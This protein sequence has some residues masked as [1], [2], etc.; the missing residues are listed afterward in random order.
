MIGVGRIGALLENDKL[1][2]KPCTHI[3]AYKVCPDVVVEAICD[4]DAKLVEETATLWGIPYVYTDYKYMLNMH[5]FNIISVATPV[6][7]HASIVTQIAQMAYSTHKPLIFCEKPLA[8]SPYEAEQMIK[9]CAKAEI[10][11]IVN[12]TRRWHSAYR[13]IKSMP[14]PQKVVAYVSGDPFNDGIHAFDLFNWWGAKENIYIPVVSKYLIFEL[15]IF[16]QDER[17]RIINNGRY[18]EHWRSEPSEFYEGYEELHLIGTQTQPQQARRFKEKPMTRA[19]ENIVDV[20]NGKSQPACTG[21]D[22]LKALEAYT[23]WKFG[24]G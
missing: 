9:E 3:G 7:T 11:L 12:H 14:S 2:E 4:L 20:L 21:L 6:N 8:T 17:I 24:E 15:D 5:T 18:V 16:Y 13:W 19:V 1:R 10:T 23:R 22:G